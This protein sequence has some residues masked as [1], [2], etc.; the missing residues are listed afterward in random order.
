MIGGK[1]ILNVL[2]VE[3]PI[4]IFYIASISAHDLAHISYAD[5]RRL[6]EEQR[7]VEKY[8]G[9]QRPISRHRIAEIREYITAPDATFPTAVIVAIDE[10]CVE[11]EPVNDT[12]A[13]M[14]LQPF[15]PKS[16]DD[17]DEIPMS[18]IAKVLDGQHRIAGFLDDKN[19]WM[20]KDTT[21]TFFFNI[22]IFVSADIAQQAN[23]FATVNLAQTKVNKSLVYDLSE[24]A[25]TDSPYKTCHNVAV[26]LDREDTSPFY[27]RIKRL[28]TAT[29][30]RRSEPLTQAAF[31]ESLLP[32][33][34]TEPAKDRNLLFEGKRLPLATSEE[35]QETPFRNLFIQRREVDMTEI[36]Y[37][38][39]SAIRSKWP[40]SWNAYDVTGNLLPRSNA[41]KAFMKYLLQ[42]VYLDAVGNDIG[43]IPTEDKFAGYFDDLEIEDADFTT[44][45]FVP[46]SGGQAM[47]LKMLRREISLADMLE[48]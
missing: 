10:R 39:F 38:Y 35:L 28:S 32:F 2:Q 29:P 13:K 19:Q 25:K 48:K 26:A 1:V 42:D 4:G 23:I 14:T 27:K 47:F 37:N 11:V 6:A 44:K 43:S 24:L 36:I 8:L 5:V 17:G 20:F 46:G 18:R 33:I 22:A 34:T 9:I 12:C 45:H 16:A 15:V 40:T 21:K 7:D 3:Q 31:V 30:G 41:F